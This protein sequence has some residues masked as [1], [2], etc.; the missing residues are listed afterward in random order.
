MN[1]YCQEFL[2]FIQGLFSNFIVPPVEWRYDNNIEV[3]I[4]LDAGG[5]M[6]HRGVQK[7]IVIMLV[8]QLNEGRRHGRVDG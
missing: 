3:C 8:V 5:I 6:N 1:D 2:S 7:E 4:L